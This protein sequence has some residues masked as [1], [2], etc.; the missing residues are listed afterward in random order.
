VDDFKLC[1]DS[2]GCEKKLTIS[3][4][5]LLDIK[6]VKPNF[7]FFHI[8]HTRIYFGTGILNPTN[9]ILMGVSGDSITIFNKKF[10]EKIHS[11]TNTPI[12]ILA[13]GLN[14]S[15][16]EMTWGKLEIYIKE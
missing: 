15:G 8:K 1:L 12:T 9:V 14:N 6:K 11:N 2:F 3:K 10:L 16:K 4:K 5:Q 13:E 7:K